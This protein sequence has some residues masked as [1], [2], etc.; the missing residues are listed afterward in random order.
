M[1]TLQQINKKKASIKLIFIEG[2]IQ[3][4][5]IDY[6]ND[7]EIIVKWYWNN[8]EW[9]S[10]ND[11]CEPRNL[12]EIEKW[13]VLFIWSVTKRCNFMINLER[14]SKYTSRKNRLSVIA[15]DHR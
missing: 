1:I 10:D 5:K 3:N 13:M 11:A 15:N 4:R 12:N 14:A 9:L 7:I 8:N 2:N 6:L